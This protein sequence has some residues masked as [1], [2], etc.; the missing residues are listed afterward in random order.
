[1]F[2]HPTTANLTRCGSL[3]RISAPSERCRTCLDGAELRPVS[4]TS[5]SERGAM[6]PKRRLV[7][8]ASRTSRRESAKTPPTRTAGTPARKLIHFTWFVVDTRTA[9]LLEETESLLF[10]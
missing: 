2:P 6:V 10:G 8:G 4:H 1:M 3:P 7:S 5:A 9:R